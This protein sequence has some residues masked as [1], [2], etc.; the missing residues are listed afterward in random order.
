MDSDH[1]AAWLVTDGAIWAKLSDLRKKEL[2]IWLQMNGVDPGNVPVE[3]SVMLAQTGPEDW[4]IWYEEYLRS[5]SGNI[6]LD[7]NDPDAAYVGECA[8]D[9]VID[10]PLEWLVPAWEPGDLEDEKS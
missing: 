8:V 5:E 2:K 3:S 9:L 7:P 4:Q 1:G 6:M 10:P